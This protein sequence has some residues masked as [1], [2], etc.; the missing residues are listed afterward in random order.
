[1]VTAEDRNNFVIVVVILATAIVSGILI[2]GFIDKMQQVSN[3][4]ERTM[5]K[6]GNKTTKSLDTLVSNVTNATAKSSHNSMMIISSMNNMSNTING[7]ITN[8]DK[9][10]KLFQTQNVGG[11]SNMTGT[12]ASLIAIFQHQVYEQH[13]TNLWLSN[14]SKQLQ[15]VPVTPI[16]QPS[17]NTGCTI[18]TPNVCILPN[19]GGIIIGKH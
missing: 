1:M 12:I 8:L 18:K 15:I 11:I 14:I 13:Q 3:H 17:N 5:D 16:P 4:G 6:I 7:S 9:N 10:V 19:G 2:S